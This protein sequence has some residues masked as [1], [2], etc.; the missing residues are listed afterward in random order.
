M[1][2]IVDDVRTVI[3]NN[4]K[5]ICISGLDLS[6]TYLDAFLEITQSIIKP[7]IIQPQKR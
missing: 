1:R 6:K 3:Q 5:Y 4:P 7:S 2:G